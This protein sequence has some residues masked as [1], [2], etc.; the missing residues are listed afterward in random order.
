L[1]YV[2][3]SLFLTLILC[4]FACV[5]LSLPLP[6]GIPPAESRT[7]TVGCAVGRRGIRAWAFEHVEETRARRMLLVLVSAFRCSWAPVVTQSSPGSAFGADTCGVPVELVLLGYE[8]ASSTPCGSAEGDAV[9]HG[10]R[11]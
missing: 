1:L 9:G 10:M 8:T 7:V 3:P 2:T 5:E 4:F 11:P 6:P